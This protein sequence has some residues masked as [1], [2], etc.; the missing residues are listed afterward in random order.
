M[1]ELTA[2]GLNYTHIADALNAESYK[3]QT[4]NK[5]F[6]TTVS[7]TPARVPC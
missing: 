2:K 3:T 5:W 7:R 1:T 6:P 4:G